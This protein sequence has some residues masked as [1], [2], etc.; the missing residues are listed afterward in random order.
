[1]TRFETVIKTLES[2]MHRRGIDYSLENFQSFLSE[3]G[4]P[5]TSLPNVIHVAGTNGKGSTVA[6]LSAGLQKMG[7][8]VGTYTSPHLYS[9]T[10]RLRINDTPITEEAFADLFEPLLEK[11]DRVATEFELLTAGAFTWFVEQ[12]PDFVIIET[13]L[14]GRLDATNVVNP[15]CSVITKIGIDHAAILGNTIADISAEK[16]GIIKPNTPVVTFST[17]DDDALSVI[18]TTAQKTTSKLYE[19]PPVTSLPDTFPLQGVF[20]YENVALAAATLK[21]LLPSIPISLDTFQHTQHPG[22]F[23]ITERNGHTVVLDGAHNPAAMSALLESLM[24][25]FPEKEF[26]FVMGSLQT[27]DVS[28]MLYL[29]QPHAEKLYWVDFWPG[30]SVPL[31]GLGDQPNMTLLSSI[32]SVFELEIPKGAVVVVTGSMHFLGTFS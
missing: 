16:A 25:Y 12:S 1:M 3:I 22:R 23:Q 18:R 4:N 9:Y 11:T 27:K 24:A 32:E 13:G 31:T 10:E 26:V 20:Q 17:Q 19:V 2:F 15:L 30:M 5:H 6:L 8:S 28:K 21:C 14:G 29:V 7:F